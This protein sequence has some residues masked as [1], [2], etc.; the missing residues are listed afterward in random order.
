MGLANMEARAM[1]VGAELRIESSGGNGTQLTMRMPY[2]LPMVAQ[3]AEA[4][5]LS[6]QAAK[7]FADGKS[8]LQISAAAIFV[9][10]TLLF[11]GMLAI[12]REDLPAAIVV[13]TIVFGVGGASGVF[14]GMRSLV[15]GLQ[16]LRAVRNEVGS[17]AP[18]SLVLRYN[19]WLAATMIPMFVLIFVPSALIEPF[20]TSI[21]LLIGMTALAAVIGGFTRAFR[22]YHRYIQTLS[23]SALR[24]A[25]HEDFPESTWSRHGWM[26]SLLMM[27]NLLFDFPPQ[28]PPLERGDWMDL[29]LPTAGVLFLAASF[30]Y[31]RYHRNINRRIEAEEVV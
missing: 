16:A 28:F 3:D 5:A 19:A 18:P 25:A 12:G 8:R 30:V 17:D 9:S 21:A 20:G 2:A 31:W 6:E 26:W 23:P 14:F 10:F 27:M 29:S 15:R 13:L 22:L 24:A 1:A 11:V 4:P 7:H